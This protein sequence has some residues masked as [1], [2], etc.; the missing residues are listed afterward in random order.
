MVGS[1]LLLFINEA[2]L[3]ITTSPL[4]F[5][6]IR[7]YRFFSFLDFALNIWQ[8]IEDKCCLLI[9]RNRFFFYNLSK[10]TW[11]LRWSSHG[12]ILIKGSY[13]Y[14]ATNS[15]PFFS[16]FKSKLNI[17]SELSIWNNSSFADL[18]PDYILYTYDNILSFGFW[19]VRLAS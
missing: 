19:F 3:S 4:T 18:R 15:S 11:R 12:I 14:P 8:T 10:N 2:T 13:S 9:S 1:H 5:L 16:T 17:L 7:G 6:F